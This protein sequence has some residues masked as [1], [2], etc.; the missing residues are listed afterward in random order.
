MKPLR[1]FLTLV[2]LAGLVKAQTLPACASPSLPE[3][4]KIVLKDCDDLY[5]I[6]CLCTQTQVFNDLVNLTE[7]VCNMEETG[8]I[9]RYGEY[10]CNDFAG[11]N[12]SITAANDT[13]AYL[14]P[15]SSTTKTNPVNTAVNSAVPT[16]TFSGDASRV[17]IVT[18]IGL[19]G[20]ML[21]AFVL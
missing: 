2:S 15:N 21:G 18:Q 7:S 13:Q 17:N 3:A 8:R 5:D 20:I 6:E 19:V 4:Y 11:T 1:I 12:Y 10:F 9:L 16:A 14:H